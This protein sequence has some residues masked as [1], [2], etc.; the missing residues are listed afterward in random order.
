MARC[1]SHINKR[2]WCYQAL[3]AT[4]GCLS[5]ASFGSPLI[6]AAAVAATDGPSLPILRSHLSVCILEGAA[7][8][9][10]ALRQHRFEH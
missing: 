8:T 4:A 2:G 7:D 10:N 1:F 6:A 5:G 9:A 3:L